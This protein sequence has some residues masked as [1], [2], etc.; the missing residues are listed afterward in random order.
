M[1]LVTLGRSDALLAKEVLQH[2]LCGK[3]I[4]ELNIESEVQDLLDFIN[5]Q[6]KSI[7]EEEAA[8]LLNPRQ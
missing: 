1:A 4:K 3:D 2:A 6:L 5:V 8:T 7:A